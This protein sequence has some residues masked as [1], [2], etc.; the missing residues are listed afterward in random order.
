MCV[1]LSIFNNFKQRKNCFITILLRHCFFFSLSLCFLCQW[2]K[3]DAMHT[4]FGN[5]ASTKNT[6]IP[7]VNFV[8]IVQIWKWKFE[9]TIV[10]PNS[11]NRTNDNNKPN[12]EKMIKNIKLKE[13]WKKK[14]TFLHWKR[15]N[16]IYEQR[17]SD[18][19]RTHDSNRLN[20][21]VSFEANQ[22][23][24]NKLHSSMLQAKYI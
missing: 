3:H 7:G 14:S 18:V 21:W 12:Q 17:Q 19:N 8:R 6:K 20:V 4:N 9:T 10:K 16:T 24:L 1:R 5:L 23:K 13:G 22:T 15:A 2:L 11:R